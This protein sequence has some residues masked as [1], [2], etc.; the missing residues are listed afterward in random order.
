MKTCVHLYLTEFFLEREMYET[1]VLEEIETQISCSIIF[2][3]KS[4][5][6]LDNVEKCGRTGQATNCNIIQ[7][8]RNSCCITKLQTHT[9]NM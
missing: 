2:F 7:R 9:Q 3:R 1:K 8:T 6:F 4:C 5:R